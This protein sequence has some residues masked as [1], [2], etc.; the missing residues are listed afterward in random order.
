M[1]EFVN[2]PI[3]A[4][5]PPRY[6][7]NASDPLMDNA[8]VVVEVDGVASAP[9]PRVVPPAAPAAAGVCSRLMLTS[10]L[11]DTVEAFVP[12]PPFT[13]VALDGNGVGVPG[14]NI[15]LK[16]V[17]LQVPGVF[18]GVPATIAG[19]VGDTAVSA[20]VTAPCRPRVFWAVLL[21]VLAF[22]VRMGRGGDVPH[23][24]ALCC[25][26]G[27]VGCRLW[28]VRAAVRV[29]HCKHVSTR[30]TV[31]LCD[32]VM[33]RYPTPNPHPPPLSHAFS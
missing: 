7:T 16:V 11:P 29:A 27:R 9:S 25:P 30:W 17:T 31:C 6:V 28:F 24:S 22:L 4:F 10:P 21:V 2:E 1:C 26:R 12:L 14:M 3:S 8:R 32:C 18:L 23:N 5:V 13:V 19:V 15:S 33:R 20:V